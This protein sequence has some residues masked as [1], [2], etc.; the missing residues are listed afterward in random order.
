M[1]ESE[2]AGSLFELAGRGKKQKEQVKAHEVLPLPK[3]PDNYVL[4]E[5]MED[6]FKKF[7]KMHE[8]IKEK[9]EN[10]YDKEQINLREINELMSNPKNFTSQEW[11]EL[12]KMKREYEEKLQQLEKTVPEKELQKEEKAKTKGSC[13]TKK[14]W[15]SMH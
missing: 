8:E 2:K 13:V 10:A 15:L 9:I 5:N 12:E 4:E 7:E 3:V 11:K 14:G 1:R 6:V